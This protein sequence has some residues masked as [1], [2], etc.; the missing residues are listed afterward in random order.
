M[1]KTLDL[2]GMKF[3]RLTVVEFAEHRLSASGVK[4]RYWLCKCEC[5]N[6]K[7][8]YT[9]CLVNGGSKSCGCLNKEL[10]S[11]RKIIK[12]GMV[13]TRP[14][15][16]WVD[17]KR[18]CN[19]PK[20]KAYKY[21]GEKGVRVCDEWVND[22]SAFYEWAK[23]NGYND[24]LTLDRIDSDGNYE[25]SNCRWATKTEQANNTSRNVFIT[26]KNK[27]QTISMWAKEL[28]IKYS[29]IQDRLSAGWTP[30]EIFELPLGTK[31]KEQKL[32][33]F[34]GETH[35]ISEWSRLLNISRKTITNRIKDGLPIEKVLTPKTD[36]KEK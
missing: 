3:G 8:V 31:L 24:N 22:F 27:T 28:G 14:Y 5:G 19:N 12:H 17:M 35:N 15:K 30:E 36:R 9:K 21:Y 20:N 4:K 1:P 2:T 18:R 7:I 26:Y 11:Q 34:N 6:Q 23:E 25:P 10:R 16:I 29:L 32:I 33:T 13:K